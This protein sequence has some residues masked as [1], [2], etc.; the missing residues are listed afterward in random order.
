MTE[1]NLNETVEILEDTSTPTSPLVM[2][3]ATFPDKMGKETLGLKTA[4]SIE[5]TILLHP[6]YDFNSDEGKKT[7]ELIGDIIPDYEHPWENVLRKDFFCIEKADIVIYDLDSDLDTHL[8]A[9]AICYK[10]PIIA[11]SNV[12]ASVPAYFSGLVFCTVKPKQLPDII[13]I[14]QSDYN[15]IKA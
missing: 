3:V 1:E 12:M 13:K 7:L 5:N 11:V 9:A 14:F 15:F 10:K 8:I 4:A 6:C 2:F